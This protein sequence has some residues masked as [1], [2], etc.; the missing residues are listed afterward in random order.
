MHRE[1]FRP[2]LIAVKTPNLKIENAFHFQLYPRLM[3]DLIDLVIDSVFK[4]E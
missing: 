2:V 1:N 4:T 3:D